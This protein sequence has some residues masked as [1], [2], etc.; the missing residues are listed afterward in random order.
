MHR[1]YS[2]LFTF[3]KIL[4]WNTQNVTTLHKT[5][6]SKIRP[7]SSLHIHDK[8]LTS[9]CLLCLFY[10]LKCLFLGTVRRARDLPN[11]NASDEIPSLSLPLQGHH[12]RSSQTSLTNVIRHRPSSRSPHPFIVASYIIKYYIVVAW[13][14][15]EKPQE[16]FE[17]HAN[18]SMLT[19]T[20]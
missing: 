14:L 2:N 6:P 10:S 17:L 19:C 5:W 7:K 9:S 16:C 1:C 12:L 13:S 11:V 3:L 15:L 20:W 18:I 4:V 8:Q